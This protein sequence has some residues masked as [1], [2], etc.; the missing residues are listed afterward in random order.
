VQSLIFVGR[1]KERIIQNRREDG[2]AG[3]E[4]LRVRGGKKD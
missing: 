3:E 2:E 4:L 1:E